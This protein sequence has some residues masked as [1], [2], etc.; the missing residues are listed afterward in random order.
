MILPRRLKRGEGEAKEVGSAFDNQRHCSQAE[1]EVKS[2]RHSQDSEKATCP[3]YANQKGRRGNH[4]C[5]NL[6]V[7]KA[8][9]VCILDFDARV[10]LYTQ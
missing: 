3:H 1:L 7:D 5:R 4:L 8:G 9:G 6:Q 2:G 10:L